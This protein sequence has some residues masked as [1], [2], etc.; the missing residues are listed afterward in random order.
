MGAIVY[1][2]DFGPTAHPWFPLW[3][4][5]LAVT[6]FSLAIYFWA[7]RVALPADKI[8]RLTSGGAVPERVLGEP[9]TSGVS[10]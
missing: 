5:M 3:W 7:Q 9:A 6:V 2:S 1:L 10:G 4:D 8:Q